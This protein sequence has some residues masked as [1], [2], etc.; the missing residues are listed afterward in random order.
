MKVA[1][2][3][4]L[5]GGQLRLLER[6]WRYERRLSELRSVDIRTS[7]MIVMGTNLPMAILEM[8]NP[9]RPEADLN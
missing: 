2:A 4:A 5:S 6:A 7:G 1:T 9:L 8:Y 3:L